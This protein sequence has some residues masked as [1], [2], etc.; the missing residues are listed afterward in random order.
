DDLVLSLRFKFE[1]GHRFA[2]NFS[3]SRL[4][5]AH[6]GHVLGV[7][8]TPRSLTV[9]DHMNGKFDK[10]VYTR[11]KAGE[12]MTEADFA[13]FW[14]RTT[15]DIAPDVWHD[16]EVTISGDTI[17]AVVDG[18]YSVTHASPGFD[19]PTKSQFSFVV[20]MKKRVVIDDVRVWSTSERSL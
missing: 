15:A 2:V 13:A 7:N 18:E 20:P 16:L 1:R 11:R 3:D 6:A 4:K 10:A 19:H 8:I 9:E 14:R 12:K 17:T 5:T